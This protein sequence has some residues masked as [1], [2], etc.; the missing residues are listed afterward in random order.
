MFIGHFAIGFAAKKAAPAVSLGTLFLACQLADLVWPMLVLAGIER[1]E[2]RPGITV[3]T[4]LDFVHYPWS[5]SLVALFLWGAAFAFGYKLLR[6]S[7]W[8]APLV[9]AVLVLSHWVLD[10][11]THRPDMP[12]TPAGPERLGLGLWNSLPATIA[13]ELVLFGIGVA[14]YQ[15]STMPKDKTGS[16]AFAG[17]VAFLLIVYFVNLFS[18]P[19]PSSGAVA[20]GALAMWLLVAWGFWIDRHREPRSAP[21]TSSRTSS[22]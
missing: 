20:W 13:V 4:P 22:R 8:T 17:L 5:H 3:V 12:L 6:R 16:R 19:P 18:P 7:P 9:L 1:V 2:I 21:V 14:I 11:L 10:V 15:R